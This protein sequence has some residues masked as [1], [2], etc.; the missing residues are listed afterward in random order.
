MNQND[1]L[2]HALVQL[3]EEI[4][5]LEKTIARA[6]VANM[7]DLGMMQGQLHGLEKAIAIVEG[8]LDDSINN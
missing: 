2:M 4:T 1:F 7:Y 8:K 3:R 6:K 5:S